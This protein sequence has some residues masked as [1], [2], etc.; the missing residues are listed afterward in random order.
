MAIKWELL[1]PIAPTTALLTQG[2]SLMGQG[3]EGLANA[4]KGLGTDTRAQNTN[5]LLRQAASVSNLA[6]LPAA[7]ENLLA[8]IAK[9]GAGADGAKALDA[10]NKQESNLYETQGNI[11]QL[12]Q[13]SRNVAAENRKLADNKILNNA[14]LVQSALAGN[15]DALD[16]LSKMSDGSGLIDMYS[17]GLTGKK[18]DIRYNQDRT[19]R[20]KQQVISNQLAMQ[21]ANI[22]LATALNPDPGG[23]TVTYEDD[24][25]GGTREVTTQKPTLGDTY[26]AVAG[27]RNADGSINLGGAA[28][29][30]AKRGGTGTATSNTVTSN[31]QSM[32]KN[33]QSN[34]ELA[35]AINTVKMT[36]P[37]H[38]A[39]LA[40]ESGGGGMGTDSGS[41]V[42][43]MQINKQYAAGDAKNFNIKGDPTKD[44]NANLQVGMAKINKLDKEF[45]GNLD[46][47]GIGYN[48]GEN[49]ARVA[50]NAWLKSGKQGQVR[51]YIPSTFKK[52]GG[53]TGNYDVQQMRNHAAKYNEAHDRL[54]ASIGKVSNRGNTAAVSNTATTTKTTNSGF[55]LAPNALNAAKQTYQNTLR[56]NQF[57]QN[58]AGRKGD[59]PVQLNAFSNYLEDQ[60]INTK[61]SLINSATNDSQNV[62]NILNKDPKWQSLPAASK[63]ASLKEA[64]DYNSKNQGW[65]FG[66]NADEGKITTR[67]ARK[68]EEIVSSKSTGYDEANFS[69][70]RSIAEK[71]IAEEKGRKGRTGRLPTLDEMMKLVDQPMYNLMKNKDKKVNNPF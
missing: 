27:S 20:L 11:N 26:L 52:T 68:L 8:N 24:G 40:I 64:I 30:A 49:A 3:I 4:A 15:P 47:I 29:N 12:D 63:Q 69:S 46:A 48:G 16:S 56:G 53:G 22:Q 23:V 41:S 9:F 33:I 21:G 6:D 35:R 65:L 28:S 1:N 7:R 43:P 10:L 39:M 61:G 60:G 66:K 13:Y 54:S 17:K 2:S 59:G 55:S 70:L 5:E 50:Y 14:A 58:A 62:F 37:K 71:A 51:D 38:L 25:Q 36:S 57:N 18:D 19:D 42:G 34:P 32:G 67:A 31:I 44:Y 45:N